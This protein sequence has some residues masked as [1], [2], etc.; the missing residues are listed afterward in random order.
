MYLLS[1][2]PFISKCLCESSPLNPFKK[3]NI[4]PVTHVRKRMQIIVKIKLQSTSLAQ[5]P[6]REGLW[7]YNYIVPYFCKL[8]KRTITFR[9]L[10]FPFWLL[11]LLHCASARLGWHWTICGNCLREV[12][13]RLHLDG[14]W[15]NIFRKW[16]APRK[17]ETVPLTERGKKKQKPLS[18]RLPHQL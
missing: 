13:V 18:V 6:S 12:D 4:I 3:L 2:E 7:Q 8:Y 16:K 5:A 10:L 14:V 17:V 1:Q 9:W 15:W 11:W